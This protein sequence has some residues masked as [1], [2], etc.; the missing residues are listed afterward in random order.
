[1]AYGNT[2][3]SKR[4]KRTGMPM[5][6]ETQIAEDVYCAISEHMAKAISFHEQLADY[7][8]FLGLHGYKKMLEYQ[9]M[10]ECEAKRHLHKRYI[11]QHHKIII[12]K[13]VH[14]P[15]LIP[16]DWSKYKTTDIDDSLIPKFVKSALDEYKKWEEQTKEFLK[17]QCAI[18]METNMIPDYEYVK[19]MIVDVEH[20]LKKIRRMTDSLNGTGYDV[21]MIHGSQDKYYDE[22]KK[23]FD[24]KFTTRNNHR[25]YPEPMYDP[26]N[27]DRR[28]YM[29]DE[30]RMGYERYEHD[31]DWDYRIDEDGNR[32]RR[33]GYR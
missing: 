15:M 8:C 16:K 10:D 17:E 20:E 3:D 26:Y 7:F 4:V 32:K 24:D 13:E 21:T 19:E 22:Y 5:S 18:L 30:R 25:P 6:E 28:R 1:M 11:D 31:E 9:Y 33:I 2:Y 23:K 12:P 27:R 29:T 14:A